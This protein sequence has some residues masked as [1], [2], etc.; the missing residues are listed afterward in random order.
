MTDDL[1][2]RADAVAAADKFDGLV[3]NSKWCNG[4]AVA[5]Q[6]IK[7]MIL[8]LPAT[9]PAQGEAVAVWYGEMPESNGKRNWTA[10]L[11]RKGGGVHMD[12]FCFARSEYP[13]RVRY[14]ADRMRWII[15]ELPKKPYILDYDADLHSGYVAP[16]PPDT[17]GADLDALVEELRADA[18]LHEDLLPDRAANAITALRA[19]LGEVR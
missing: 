2:S 15:G 11:H 3:T 16:T 13:D 10:S 12:G 1:I 18:K 8:A 14:E 4:Q 17:S 7:A 19:K 9:Q 5:A 6:Q